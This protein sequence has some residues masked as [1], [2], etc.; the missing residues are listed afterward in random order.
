[1]DDLEYLPRMPRDPAVPIGCIGSG[2]IMADCHLVAY[3][4][5][6]FQPL[7][8]ATRRRQQAE[9]TAQRH[10]IE[11]VYDSYQQLLDDER[12][13]VI[14]IAVPPDVQLEVISEVVLRP[15]IRGVLAQKPLAANTYDAT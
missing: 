15:H 7:A 3:R 8:I 4:K 11:V 10:S 1:M 14:D 6:G 13:Q 12:L 5:A 9:Q 2:F